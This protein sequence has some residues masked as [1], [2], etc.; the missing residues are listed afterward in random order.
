VGID[1]AAVDARGALLIEAGVRLRAVVR[2]VDCIARLGGDEFA[3][4]FAENQAADI[5]QV[6]QRIAASFRPPVVFK[7]ASMT[8]SASIGVARFPEHGETQVRLYKSV[9]LALYAAKRA[10]RKTWPAYHP[11]MEAPSDDR[12]DA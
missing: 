12:L 8:T 6:C 7:G 2:E 10:G 9:D 4:L 5:D 3:I 11:E 1:L